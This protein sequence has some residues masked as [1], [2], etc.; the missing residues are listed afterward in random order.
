LI[1]DII[2][3]KTYAS[4]KLKSFIHLTIFV[5]VR[6]EPRTNASKPTKEVRVFTGILA[7]GAEAR[8]ELHALGYA[9]G[10]L[11]KRGKRGFR[12]R[13]S[14]PRYATLTLTRRAINKWANVGGGPFRGTGQMPLRLHTHV[15]A[16]AL[17]TGGPRP[18]RGSWQALGPR[19]ARAGGS[20]GGLSPPL[21]VKLL[22]CFNC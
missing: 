20:R 10:D 7:K 9:N 2:G 21:Y 6:H 4:V 12:V 22:H 1:K 19:C 16:K 14:N 3:S 5:R 11:V 13:V 17:A 15:A 8:N 18:R